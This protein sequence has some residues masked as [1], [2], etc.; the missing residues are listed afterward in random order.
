MAKCCY[1]DFRLRKDFKAEA[2]L[3]VR[4]TQLFE[5]PLFH[6]LQGNKHMFCVLLALRWMG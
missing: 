2:L 6:L 4:F 3:H 5:P 1:L